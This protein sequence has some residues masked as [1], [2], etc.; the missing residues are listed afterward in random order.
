MNLTI[1]QVAAL[2][3]DPGSAAAGKKL[4]NP[5]TW[6]ALGRSAEALWGQCQGTALY[7]VRVALADLATKCSCPSRKFPCKHSLGLLLLAAG[8]PEKVPAKDP[9]EWVTE[10]LKKRAESAEKKEKRKVAAQAPPDPAA[11]ARRAE[12]RLERVAQGLEAL[13]LWMNDLVRTGVAGVETQGPD[14]WEAQAARL[15]DAQAPAVATRV[16]RMAEIPRAGPDWPQ[17]LLLELGRLALLTHASRRIDLLDPPLQADVRQLLGWTVT[18]EDV[19]AA[20]DVVPDDWL[21]LGQWVDDDV[22][23]RVQ[24]NWL[25]GLASGREALV[26]Q[27]SAGAAPFPETLV[28]GTRMAA[29]LAFWPSASPQ[30]ALV[31]RRGA[32]SPWSGPLPG[33]DTI[34]AFLA[35][36]AD[37]LARQPWLERFSCP[38]RGVTP[39]VSGETWHVVDGAGE[40]LPLKGPDHWRLLAVSGG[41][42]VDVA[43]E[44]DGDRLLALG[45]AV[46][47]RYEVLWTGRT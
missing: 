10:W 19:I 46:E 23:L 9:P 45:A 38:L 41:A 3:P 22:R 16:R 17:R 47:G 40:A 15:V 14:V 33:H 26:L 4:A 8:Q 30:R 35:S 5:A 34:A 1:E 24:R 6:Q 27:F 20:G 42:P 36:V 29:D 37:A 39:V 25:R 7:Q 44:W 13:D 31:T 11:Q 28:P 21:V 12:R 43:G 32:A 18:Q 2:A